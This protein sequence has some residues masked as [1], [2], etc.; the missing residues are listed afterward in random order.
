MTVTK[1]YIAPEEKDKDTKETTRTWHFW[2]DRPVLSIKHT[3]LPFVKKNV[4]LRPNPALHPPGISISNHYIVSGPIQMTRKY[5]RD[6]SKLWNESYRTTEWSVKVTE[7]DITEILQV[8]GRITLGIL[9][10]DGSILG[11]ILSTPLH[12]MCMVGNKECE[13][14]IVEGLVLH[15]LIRGRGAA[16]WLLGWLDHITSLSHPTTHIWFRDSCI[17][18]QQVLPKSVVLPTSVEYVAQTTL[19]KLASSNMFRDTVPVSWKE[20]SPIL[21]SLWDSYSIVF[22]PNK[23][24][25]NIYWWRSNI[26]GFPTSAI[27]VGIAKTIRTQGNSSIYHVVFSCFV[28]IRES[29]PHEMSDPFWNIPGE[30]MCEMIREGIEAAAIA[31]GCDVLQVYS[32]SFSSDWNNRIWTVLKHHKRKMYM[33]NRIPPSMGY[34]NILFPYCGV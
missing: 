27:L 10:P 8:P 1:R 9:G 11:T 23:E 20:V 24:S 12:G 22:H 16:G 5:A 4:L 14:R 32:H 19:S 33:Y 18:K 7:L 6:I 26:P 3:F 21:Q 34:S 17:Q 2:K 30:P 29:T 15:P 25:S 28:R 31:Q 13:I